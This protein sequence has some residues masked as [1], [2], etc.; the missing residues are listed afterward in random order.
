[1]SD[2]R[3]SD[4][5]R[6]VLVTGGSRGIG[7]ELAGQFAADGFDPIL[8]ARDENR[9]QEAAATLSERHG[10]TGYVLPMDL[11]GPDAGEELYD[12]VTAAGHT[13][14][15]LVNNAGFG[16]YERFVDGDLGTDRELLN[17]HVVTVTTLC[18][19]FGREMVERGHGYILNNASI[20]GFLPM[21]TSAVYSAAKH[22]ER[23]LTEILAEEFADTGVTVTALCPGPTDTGFMDRGGLAAAAYE[24]TQLMAPAEVATAG[25]EGLMDGRRLVIPGLVNKLRVFARR[26]LPRRVVLA[27]LRQAQTGE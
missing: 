25:Y 26:L 18:K 9:L 12:R 11:S 24:R 23:A 13:V 2:G 17:L 4:D 1:M 19:L 16:T 14:D 7:Y 21:P 5:G 10:V 8:V 27:T 3:G 20:L 6:T 15:A 22:Y